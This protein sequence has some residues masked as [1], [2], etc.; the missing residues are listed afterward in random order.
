MYC[1]PNESIAELAVGQNGQVVVEKSS[2]T[3]LLWTPKEEDAR[4]R[5]TA[6][7]KNFLLCI[8]LPYNIIKI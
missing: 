5:D 6:T 1:L 8:I 7:I 4:K 2:D 3:T